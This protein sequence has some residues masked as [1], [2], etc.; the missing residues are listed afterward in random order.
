[1]SFKR[2]D[3]I[4]NGVE[5]YRDMLVYMAF[6]EEPFSKSTCFDNVLKESVDFKPLKHIDIEAF[7]Q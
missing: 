1:M 7:L 3:V 4:E 5:F 6:S 2:S